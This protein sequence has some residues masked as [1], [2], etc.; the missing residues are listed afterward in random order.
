VEEGPETPD[1]ES[2]DGNGPEDDEDGTEEEIEELIRVKKTQQSNQLTNYPVTSEI[3]APTT[4]KKPV[5]VEVSI[6]LEEKF[7]ESP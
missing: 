2:W 3:R 7:S 1:T 6:F 4:A 5:P